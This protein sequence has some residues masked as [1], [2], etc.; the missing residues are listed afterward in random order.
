MLLDVLAELPELKICTAYEIDGQRVTDFPSH[1]DDLRRAKPVFE[2]LPGWQKDI[3]KVR[4]LEDLPK[5]ARSYLDRLSVLIERPVQVVSIGPDR[6]Q[7]IFAGR[8]S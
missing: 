7:T 1:V 4:K 3:T 5:E 8:S 2:T 6:E